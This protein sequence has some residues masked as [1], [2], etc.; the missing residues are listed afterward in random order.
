MLVLIYDQGSLQ[1][2]GYRWGELRADLCCLGAVMIEP[3]F[4]MQYGCLIGGGI[5][6]ES[7]PRTNLANLKERVVQCSTS[8]KVHVS[9]TINESHGIRCRYAPW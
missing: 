1:E 7:L 8:F 2:E 6:L 3:G 5:V 4:S 9:P